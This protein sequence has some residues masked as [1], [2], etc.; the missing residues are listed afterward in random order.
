MAG[1]GGWAV[2]LAEGAGVPTGGGACRSGE[3]LATAE[4]QLAPAVGPALLSE[5]AVAP[6]YRWT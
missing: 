6:R 2:P 3:Q 5:P 1:R 4:E